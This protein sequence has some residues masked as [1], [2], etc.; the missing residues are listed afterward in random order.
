[1]NRRQHAI[2]NHLIANADSAHLFSRDHETCEAV[3]GLINLGIAKM[4]YVEDGQNRVQL[5][6]LDAA[7]RILA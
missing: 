4:V 2:I 1:M 7:K 5:K 6:S 3:C